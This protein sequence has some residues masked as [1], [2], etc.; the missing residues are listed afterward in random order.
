MGK[1]RGYKHSQ[2]RRSDISDLFA[3]SNCWL[4]L[5]DQTGGLIFITHNFYK[6]TSLGFY[7]NLGKLNGRQSLFK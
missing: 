7:K 5:S 2:L 4:P 1:E 6:T 3:A